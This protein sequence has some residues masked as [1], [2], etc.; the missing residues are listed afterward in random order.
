M[1][2]CA[3]DKGL[4]FCGECAEYPCEKIGKFHADGFVL[5]GA[6]H[7]TDI[8]DNTARL[9]SVGPIQWLLDQ[10]RR[11]TCTCGLPFSY[12]ESHCARCGESLPSYATDKQTSKEAP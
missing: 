2:N 12:Y 9:Q 7:R 5:D 1:R 11:W 6:T 8:L 4:R 10:E 3:K